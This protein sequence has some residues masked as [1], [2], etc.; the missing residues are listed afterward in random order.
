MLNVRRDL[1]WNVF[2][3][4]I[5]EDDDIN[6]YIKLLILFNPIILCYLFLY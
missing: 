1:M 2:V 5:H 6:G 4:D 3:K